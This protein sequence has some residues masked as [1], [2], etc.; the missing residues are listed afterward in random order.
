MRTL[1]VVAH[2]ESTHHVDGLVGGWYDSPL[3][4]AGLRAATKIAE[5]LRGAIPEQDAIEVYS[6]DLQ[7]AARTADIIGEQL[8]VRPVLDA[9]WREKSYGAAEGK[10]QEW[11][12][13]RFVT[14]P[15]VGE[16]L[17][18]DEGIAGSETM[19]GFGARVYAAMDAVL[20]SDCAHQVVVTHGG[21]ITFAVA[22]W[23]KLP[24]ESLAYA[25]FNGPSGS[26]TE[27]REDDYFH[28]RQV[29]RLGDTRHLS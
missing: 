16:R 5:A 24:I 11:L 8:R 3:T 21:A 2:P 13:Q 14:P 23:T 4:P 27:L 7:R 22:A 17:R 19:Y 15:A 12:R 28:N 10:P 9:R 20:L 26:I 6:S 1:Y 18:H 25:R 29:V